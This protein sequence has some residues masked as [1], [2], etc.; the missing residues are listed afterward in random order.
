MIIMKA[1]KKQL[2]LQVVIALSITATA[3]VYTTPNIVFDEWFMVNPSAA[4]I[5]DNTSLL[6]SS[7][8]SSSG[9]E[10]AP[11]SN[12]L[13]FRS[14]LTESMGA[15]LKLNRDTRGNFRSTSISASYAY[16]VQLLSEHNIHFGLSLGLN[17]QNFDLSNLD[18]FDTEDPLLQADENRQNILMNEIGIHYRWNALQAGV[19]ANYLVQKYNHFIGYATYSY[20]I[21]GVEKLYV[22]PYLLYQYLPESTGQLDLSLKVGYDMFWCSYSYKTNN[23][24]VTAFGVSYFNFDLAYGYK[25][26]RSELT[27]IVS[28]A[29]QIILRYNFQGSGR[30]GEDKKPWEQ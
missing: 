19:A 17:S 16:R 9:I 10:A 23:D 3:Q 21:P 20:G 27:S 7:N 24:M 1:I 5:Y 30:S 15:G 8:I 14:A 22:A 2:V 26:N 29:N 11:M 13:L 18:V 6:A 28:C 12:F 25:F 4:N